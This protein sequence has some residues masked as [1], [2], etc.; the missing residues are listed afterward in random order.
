PVRRSLT[1][2]L[3]ELG[4]RAKDLQA[5][6]VAEPPSRPERWLVDRLVHTAGLDR[7]NVLAMT[8][9]QAVDAWTEHITRQR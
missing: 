1:A 2:I 3:D 6:P 4:K 8:S 7:D 5:K 9:E